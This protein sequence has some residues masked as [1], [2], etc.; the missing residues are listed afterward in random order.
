MIKTIQ[1]KI[2][3][4]QP[5]CNTYICSITSVVINTI[6]HTATKTLLAFNPQT[7]GIVLQ[8]YFLSPSM[9]SI[10]FITSRIKEMINANPPYKI[11]NLKKRTCRISS[12]SIC[13]KSIFIF[14]RKIIPTT[15]AVNKEMST[16]PIKNFFF[17]E[18]EY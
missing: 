4:H 11:A 3:N 13:N 5:Y 6:N 8:P 16:L 17:N 12:R 7:I 1:Y 9:S 2:L 10:S 14:E 18:E 15:H